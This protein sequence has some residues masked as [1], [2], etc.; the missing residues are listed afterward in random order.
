MPAGGESNF[1]ATKTKTGHPDGS[2]NPKHSTLNT[3]QSGYAILLRN[4]AQVMA[5][6]MATLSDSEVTQPSG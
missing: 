4:S 3:K 5:V 2:L 6:A 1:V